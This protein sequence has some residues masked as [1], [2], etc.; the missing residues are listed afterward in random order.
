MGLPY[1]MSPIV[2]SVMK[3]NSRHEKFIPHSAVLMRFISVAGPSARWVAVRPLEE[4][5]TQSIFVWVV[6]FE[7]GAVMQ[8]QGE[9]GDRCC[10]GVLKLRKCTCMIVL[11]Q[12]Y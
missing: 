2:L 9:G 4:V 1:V 8:R 3:Y 6:G 7:D 12:T 11:G 10:D 5:P